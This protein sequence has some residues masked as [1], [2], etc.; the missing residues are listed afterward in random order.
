MPTLRLLVAAVLASLALIAAACGDDDTSA[1]DA[2]STTARTTEAPARPQEVSKDLEE[3]PSIS[4][5]QGDP[6]SELQSTDIVE[7][8]GRAAKDGDNVTVQYVGV[9]WS[10]GAEF[11]ASWTSGQ[12]F[13]FTLGTGN[14]I[15]GWDEGVKGMKPGGRRMLV[16][17]PDK[18]YGE[19]GSPPAIGPDETLIFVIDLEKT[20]SGS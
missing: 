12:P 11:D 7:G 3:K 5:G 18:A 9:N 2:A 16:I 10:N 20:S 4:P 1:S 13:E 15:A 17:P 6:P 14:V 8:K 19:Q